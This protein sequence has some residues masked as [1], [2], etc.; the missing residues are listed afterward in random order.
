MNKHER[1]LLRRSEKFFK[2]DQYRH[3]HG[4]RQVAPISLCIRFEADAAE[5]ADENGDPAETSL[6]S[7]GGAGAEVIRLCGERPEWMEKFA[8][9]CR[10]LAPQD[11]AILAALADDWRDRQAAAICHRG[12]STVSRFKKRLPGLFAEVFKELDPAG[13][14]KW[15]DKTR[16]PAD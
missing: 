14:G 3:D 16:C 12:K 1:N 11:L 13:Y 5:H 2:I 15:R 9:V 6:L 8:E 4:K 10:G 7:D